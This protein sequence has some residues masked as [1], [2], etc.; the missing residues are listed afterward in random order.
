MCSLPNDGL[1][2]S[3]IVMGNL[4]AIATS[5][6]SPTTDVLRGGLPW[7]AKHGNSPQ[8]NCL[9]VKI[10]KHLLGNISFFWRRSYWGR[11]ISSHQNAI[12]PLGR[13]FIFKVIKI[14]WGPCACPTSHWPPKGLGARRG[15]RGQT[16]GALCR[17]AEWALCN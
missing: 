17:T 15:L 5:W 14:H 6:V 9:R 1:V 10:A 11:S 3:D 13:T 8:I 12:A 2:L 16:A 7:R 4:L